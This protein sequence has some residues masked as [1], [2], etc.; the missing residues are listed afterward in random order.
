[1]FRAYKHHPKACIPTR[2]NP[3]DA[4][5]DLYSVT[6][7]T[8]PP[9]GFAKIETGIAIEVPNGY[10]GKIEDRSSMASKRMRV[11]GGVIDAGYTGSC[12]VLLHNLG[13]EPYT[14]STGDK[15]AQIIIYKV[16]TVGFMESKELWQS[17]RGNNGF[18][19]SGR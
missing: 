1:M 8:I 13:E 6:D 4:G 16:E 18:G 9:K 2:A 3:T 19:S 11:A 7:I 14:I 12:S 15:V 17:E 5:A 10:V